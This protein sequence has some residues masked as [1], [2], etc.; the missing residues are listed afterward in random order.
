LER[1]K[2]IED[3]ILE[4]NL[5][6]E[7]IRQLESLFFPEN[8]EKQNV[9]NEIKKAIDNINAGKWS[10]NFNNETLYF[11]DEVYRYFEAEKSEKIDYDFFIK[12]VFPE[13]RDIVLKTIEEAV[14]NKSS[15]DIQH[16]I[17][18]NSGKNKWIRC[19]G[20]VFINEK[21]ETVIDASCIEITE[22]VKVRKRILE[23]EDR[24]KVFFLKNPM[25]MWVYNAKTFEI[26]DVNK[27]AIEKYGY[28]EEEFLRKTIMDIRPPEDIPKLIETKEK[29]KSEAKVSSKGIWRHRK[30][31]GTIMHV[32]VKLSKLTISNKEYYLAIINDTTD[33]VIAETALKENIQRYQLLFSKANDAIVIMD[34]EKI[35]DC[36]EKTLEMFA[37]KRDEII[38][39]S[40]A[41]FSPEFQP[42]GRKSIDSALEKINNT[43]QGKPEYFYWKHIQKNGKLFDAEVS[44]NSLEINNKIYIQAI[45]RDITERKEAENKAKQIQENLIKQ[46]KVLVDLANKKTLFS[47]SFLES[48]KEISKA[49]AETLNASKSSVWMYYPEKEITAV[50]TYYLKNN[51]FDFTPILLN[52]NNYPEYFKAIKTERILA[53]KDVYNDNRMTALENY[54]KLYN[55]K[56]TLDVPVRAGGE[57]VA[58]ICNENESEQREWTF[59]E[60]TFAASLADLLSI[61]YEDVQRKAVEQK[62]IEN[63]KILKTVLDNIEHIIYNFSFS[64]NGEVDV[65]FIS[66]QIE[67]IIGITPEQFKQHIKNKTFINFYHPEDVEIIRKSAE[68]LVK[69]K[70]SINLSYRIK[71]AKTNE[72]IWIEE[73]VFPSFDKYGNRVA[74]FG[75]VHDITNRKNAEIALKQSEE[76]YRNLFE[77]NMAGV[78][79]TKADGKY[80]AVNESY[81]KIFGFN[82]IEEAL[83]SN[84]KDNY[85]TKE[86]RE[87]Y[88]KELRVKRQLRNYTLRNKKKDG[89]EIW[90]LVNVALFIDNGE[91]YLQ[92]TLIDITEM[93]KVQYELEQS[94]KKFRLLSE[95]SPIGIFL[96]DEK[97]EPK[98]V[99]NKAKEIFWNVNAQL[100]DYYNNQYNNW[101][102]F[103]HKE[104]RELII[105]KILLNEK[106]NTTPINV[107]FRIVNKNEIKWV[108]VNAIRILNE[109]GE[110]AGSIG[111]IEDITERKRNL[112]RIKESERRFRLL[113]DAA[114]EGIVITQND[115]IIDVNDRF[116]LMHGYASKDEVIGKNI[117]EF[118]LLNKKEHE[119][120]NRPIEIESKKKNGEI[121]ILE[122]KGEKIQLEDKEICISVLYD[123]SERKKYEEALKESRENY[124]NL[125]ESSPVGIIIL[126]KTLNIRFVNNTGKKIFEIDNIQT[127][128][129][130]IWDFISPNQKQLVLE[131]I[132]STFS[133]SNSDAFE[134]NII[135]AKSQQ[136]TLEVKGILINYQ[137][138]KAIQVVL[139]DISDK[140]LLQKEQLR[141]EIAE[142]TNKRLQKEIAERLN[143]EKKLI[144]NQ[145]FTKSI[146]ESSLDMICAT[147]KNDKIIEFNEAASLAF[148]YSYDEIKNH[149]PKILYANEKQYDYVLE[150]LNKKGKFSGEIENIRKD[151]TKFI[152]YLSASLLLN[153]AGEIIGS[154]GVSRDITESK[155]AEKQL[156]NALK[157]KEILLKEVHHRVKNNLQVISSILNL[158]SS[159]VND[160]KTLNILKESQ[161]R[162]KS[163]AFIHESLYQNKDFAQIKFSEYVVNLSNSLLQSYKLNNKLI[164]LKLE[165]DE[166]FI[167]LDESIPCGLIINELVSN[168]LKYA[169]SEKEKGEIEIK[170]KN[171]GK[172]L[173]LS[174]AD[175]GKG[176]PDNFKIEETPSLGLQLVSSLCEQLNA[177]LKIT[178]KQ[179]K[180][181]C[182]EIEF[183]IK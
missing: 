144:E 84:S 62:I 94:E 122:L 101:K 143:A 154:M 30:K 179:N 159:Y 40:P 149:S 130:N 52:Y 115:I 178:T 103:I 33:K 24:Y 85:F 150:Q 147:D 128:T 151:G 140:K 182:F 22:A 8:I 69:N 15:F 90:V 145:Q 87:N 171:K 139:S 99:N 91:E 116:F 106:Y 60:Q 17:I 162:V 26:V 25:P 39:H 78:F 153:P 82:S 6:K 71:N 135:T 133:G 157:E 134:L 119:K 10:Y 127:E 137:G 146:I 105:N 132:N 83:K 38:G 73:Y 165:I 48:A 46:N 107:D 141:A 156:K 181:T 63:E 36:N 175:N 12:H 136:K 43:L 67:K 104:D 23:N 160:E 11:S 126:S 51:T 4:N 42:D 64:K 14:K 95:S 169:F 177:T 168:A 98:F 96:V 35:I 174:V 163:M 79:I 77:N 131:K 123:I 50:V 70:Q 19:V 138:E 18:S 86:D 176:L 183:E 13:D 100:N 32:E 148:G 72:Y 34:K 57:I 152:S 20:K 125:I 164:D 121:I 45:V 61:A 58:I 80:I 124:K 167:N 37:C 1:K 44:L 65:K 173:Y 88:L 89:S 81:I 112:E 93:K 3:Y 76:K 53:V 109:K 142:E 75:I 111:T 117:K 120:I 54:F 56:S 5:L 170:V 9:G 155:L 92:G 28:T 29:I 172:S 74:N 47:G 180:G 118:F 102:N 108:R 41:E 66:P 166:I 2:N 68:Q 161:N 59:E 31:D 110:R 113:A 97:A 129:I 7:K 27:A 16:R 114:I 21:K 49:A 158:Q 55:I